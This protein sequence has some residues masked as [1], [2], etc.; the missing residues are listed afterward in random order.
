MAKQSSMVENAFQA[1]RVFLVIDFYF[2]KPLF[3]VKGQVPVKEHLSFLS[4]RFVGK[5]RL[6]QI[7]GHFFLGASVFRKMASHFK[8]TFIFGCS[9][10]VNIGLNVCA[11]LN[12]FLVSNINHLIVS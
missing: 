3:S 1:Q 7:R 10:G 6:K 2:L 11:S 12:H 9:M 8:R 5:N 4:L